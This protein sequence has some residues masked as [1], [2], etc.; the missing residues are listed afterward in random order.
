MNKGMCPR[1]RGL[2]LCFALFVVLSALALALPSAGRAIVNIEGHTPAALPDYDSRASVAPSADQLAAASALGANVE[3]EPLRRR[4]RPSARRRLRRPRVCRPPTPCRPRAT[5]SPRTRRCSGSIRPTALRPRR[6]SRSEARPTTTRSCSGKWRTASVSTDGVATVALVGSKAAGWNVTYAS[7]SLTGGSTDATGAVRPRSGEAWTEGRQRRGRRRLGPRRRGAEHEG[8]HDDA[9]G[10]RASRS[11]SSVTKAVFATPHHGARA[12]YD[13]TRHDER[14]RQPCRA[15]RS[16]STHRPATCSTARATSTTSPT[17]RPGR[18]PSTRAVQRPQR[19]PVE[20]PGDGQPRDLLLDGDRRLHLREGRPS[21]R[22]RT[23]AASPRSSRGTCRPRRRASPGRRTR[24]GATTSTTP[25]SGAARRPHAAAYGSA[26]LVRATSATRDYQP[27]FTD[28]WYVSGCNPDNV[29]AAINPLG[30][31]IEAS[32]VSLFVGHNVMHDF[33]YYLGF[34]EGH[35]NAQQYNNGVTT[36]TRRRRRAVRVARAPRQRRA[37]RKRPVR[38]RDRQPRQRQH[39]HRRRRQPPDDEP[40]RLAAPG[41]VVLRALRRRRV[42]LRRLRPRVRPHDREP[43]DRQRRRRP[44]GHARRLDG[45]G[46][47]RLRRAGGLQRAAPAGS[48]GRGPLHRG[49]VRHRQRL[50]RHP[51]LPR[52]PSDGRRVPGAGPEPRHG[53]AELRRLRIR[54]RRPRGARRRRD[55]DH[56]PDRPP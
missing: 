4:A 41:R 7:S 44:P 42:R 47:R 34:D 27:A 30:N 54:Q 40:V 28:A 36:A 18:H 20:L 49:R 53:S 56:S 13:A 55:L 2:R 10:A 29:N 51:R 6:L 8:R 23:R 25:G 22:T 43:H 50:Q 3:L 32:T 35:W 17:T 39:E 48:A 5:G 14:R 9:H 1:T 37:A 16:S 15:T 31:D 26:T 33:A 11:R 19:L 12:A 38:R 46:V 24:P 45:R 21:R 52:G